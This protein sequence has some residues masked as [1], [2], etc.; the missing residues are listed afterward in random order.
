MTSY[1]WIIDSL[2]LSPSEDG[3]RYVVKIVNW[4]RFAKQD[5]ILVNICGSMGCPTP[6]TD[7]F[8]DYENLTYEQ[9]CSWLDSNIDVSSLDIILND[10]INNII[11]PQI[12]VLPLPFDNPQ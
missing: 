4:R 2:Q 10:E 6:S 11:N 3:L 8:T 5:E 7:D 9:V 1:Y 12:I